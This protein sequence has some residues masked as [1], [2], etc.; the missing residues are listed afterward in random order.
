MR[1]RCPHCQSQ[2]KIRTSRPMSNLTVEHSLQC[3]VPRSR[4]DEP[5]TNNGG[6]KSPPEQLSSHFEN[7]DV[8][9]DY[10]STLIVETSL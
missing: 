5:A 9:V 1:I 7:H 10:S 3:R 4:G 6:A 8:V 2:A